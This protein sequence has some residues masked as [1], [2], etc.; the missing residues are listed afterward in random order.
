MHLGKQDV[1]IAEARQQLG[2]G[3]IIGISCYNELEQALDTFAVG[4][5]VWSPLAQGLLTGKYDNGV[6]ED[7]RYASNTSSDNFS[8]DRI[9]K[10]RSSGFIMTYSAM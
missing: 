8:E 1:S 7:S 5:V 2:E 9:T 4:A 6:P 3:K 10:A